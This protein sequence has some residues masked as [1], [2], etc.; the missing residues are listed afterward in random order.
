VTLLVNNFF[1]PSCQ[2]NH[3]NEDV[4]EEINEY[5]TQD[6][7]EQLE[8]HHASIGEATELNKEAQLEAKDEALLSLGANT[9]G[10]A[11]GMININEGFSG[12]KASSKNEDGK[13]FVDSFLRLFKGVCE[14][15]EKGLSSSKSFFEGSRLFSLNGASSVIVGSTILAG[16]SGA[17][18]SLLGLTTMSLL[19]K[20]SVVNKHK[21][22]LEKGIKDPTCSL[23]ALKAL[24]NELE[25]SKEEQ[26]SVLNALLKPSSILDQ[27][28]K[29]MMGLFHCD[30]L[31]RA[32]NKALLDP[33]THDLK[34][35]ANTLPDTPKNFLD[36]A[37]SDFKFP[38]NIESLS[39]ENKS[40]F[41]KVLVHV[42]AHALKNYH[43]KKVSTFVKIFG[44]DVKDALNKVT[45]ENPIS[46]YLSI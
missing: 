11:I 8:P 17:S 19:E 10:A 30:L 39:N 15:M 46:L 13:G 44:E 41:K 24:K 16:A 1:N 26:N 40:C 12:I 36:S 6:N 31:I 2:P 35:L 33:A 25:V 38:K 29:A 21:N 3:A 37:L 14:L 20:N 7:L 23:Q 5:I 4:L 34:Q 22:L 32:C 27:C 18:L 43:E 9:M 42:Y 45:N 28:K